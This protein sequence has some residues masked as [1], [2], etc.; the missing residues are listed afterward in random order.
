MD[1][2][3]MGISHLECQGEETGSG[4]H[5]PAEAL[6]CHETP[7]RSSRAPAAGWSGNEVQ[8]H[9]APR[10]HEGV[11][12]GGCPDDVT[13][14]PERSLGSV[15]LRFHEGSQRECG[16]EVAG[17][18]LASG[19]G[20]EASIGEGSGGRISCNVFL[21]LG[22]EGSDVGSPVGPGRPP[23][24]V[25]QQGALLRVR[26]RP[27]LKPFAAKLRNNSHLCYANSVFQ[28]LLWLMELTGT[29]VG[30]LKV[31]IGI[32]RSPQHIHLPECF[33]LRWLFQAWPRLHQQHDAGEFLAHCL[34]NAQAEAWDG[35]WQARISNP[36]RCTDEGTLLLA[37]PLPISGRTL[38]SLIDS[39]HVQYSRHAVAQHRGILFLQLE[40]Y[41]SAL[42]KNHSEIRIRPGD[43]LAV[44]VFAETTGLSTLHESFQVAIVIYHLGDSVTSD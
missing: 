44:P 22:A 17:R 36:D 28:A 38:Q 18:S 2:G 15:M 23:D 35:I 5:P 32:L 43:R 40:R 33:A 7:G 25:A 1:M 42:A 34:R 11:Q 14:Q 27:G 10:P 19:T 21:R 6:G 3:S 31:G 26:A 37:I 9:Q 16:D 4:I 39:W 41:S 29:A 12:D 8:H 24:G 13:A 20:A 30:R